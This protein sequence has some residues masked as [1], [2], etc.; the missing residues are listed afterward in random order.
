[1]KRN[2]GV[3]IIDIWY[4]PFQFFFFFFFRYVCVSFAFTVDII[5]RTIIGIRLLL[6]LSHIL[7]SQLDR[8]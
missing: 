5:I 3:I 6:N 1:M 2:L 4:I 8:P 7:Y